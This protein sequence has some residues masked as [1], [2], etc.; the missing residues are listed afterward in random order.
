V[1]VLRA[2]DGS[3]H[4]LRFA[5]LTGRADGSYASAT[6][7]GTGLCEVCHTATSFYRADGTGAAHYESNCGVCHPHTRGFLPR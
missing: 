7:P 1:D 4:P 3:D 6:A 5:A 2:S